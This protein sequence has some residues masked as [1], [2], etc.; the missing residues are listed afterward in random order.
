MVT[1]PVQFARI[2]RAIVFGPDLVYG[3]GGE[4]EPACYMAQLR[5]QTWSYGP[6]HLRSV[7]VWVDS[8]TNKLSDFLSPLIRIATWDK[9]LD[10]RRVQFQPGGR[11][12]TAWPRVQISL[13]AVAQEHQQAQVSDLV[14]AVQRAA[15]IAY[16]PAP[17]VMN[18]EYPPSGG[19][20]EYPYVGLTI[21]C[22]NGSG[23]LL[24]DTCC[25]TGAPDLGAV[26]RGAMRTLEG[27]GEPVGLDGYVESYDARLPSP[28]ALAGWDTRPGCVPE[29]YS[30]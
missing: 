5:V 21:E 19:P 22:R 16:A 26:A 12:L 15:S 13:V 9:G 23:T 6:Q 7:S 17:L 24:L 10:R 27:L 4:D 18:R 3:P 20:P 30:A 1:P 28:G 2:A 29:G 8:T 11:E 25:E 14:L